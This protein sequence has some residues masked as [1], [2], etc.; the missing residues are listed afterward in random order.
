MLKWF[1]AGRTWLL[2]GFSILP[3]YASY[4][5][6]GMDQGASNLF[7]STFVSATGMVAQF[8]VDVKAY[9]EDGEVGHFTKL[10]M[11]DSVYIVLSAR[12]GGRPGHP[13]VESTSYRHWVLGTVPDQ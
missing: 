5:G 4:H 8:E 1:Q 9:F 12:P 11:G 7:R 6:A 3:G 10:G 13:G 2:L